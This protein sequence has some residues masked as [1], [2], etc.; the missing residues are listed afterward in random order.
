M[1]YNVFDRKAISKFI[2]QDAICKGYSIHL[3]NGRNIWEALI[4]CLLDC[5]YAEFGDIKII[6]TVPQIS[7]SSKLL[8]F[9]GDHF[10]R[11]ENRIP[12]ICNVNGNKVFATTDALPYLY[13]KLYL[14]NYLFSTYTVVRPRSFA[15][16][17]FLREEFIRYFQFVFA[18]EE[19]DLR[20]SID[21]IRTATIRF[22]ERIRIPVVLVDRHS[23][24]YYLKKSC[25]HSVWANLNIESVLQCGILRKS[26]DY[27]S[28]YKKRV[29]DIGGA[30]RLLA[31]FIYVNSDSHGLFL[32]YY[33]RN[34]DII[35]KSPKKS[36]ILDEFVRCVNN[37]GGRINYVSSDLSLRV[38]RRIAI[39]ESALAIVVQRVIDGKVFLTIYNR[40]MTKSEVVTIADV[41]DWIAKKYNL[42]E[43]MPSDL[44]NSIICSRIKEGKLYLR[45][46]SK[47]YKIINDGLFN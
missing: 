44:Q 31:S 29:I 21:K 17:P 42:I 38:I 10:D 45:K 9:Y 14:S 13:S 23:D 12:C 47:N 19:C 16:K 18:I 41:E 24:S 5:F 11:I 6:D 1:L 46:G 43:R 35:I 7:E 2:S 27:G 40:D 30:Q 39:K 36:A 32:P 8:D 26:F 34:F 15:V 4:N 22:F 25:F 28:G 20:C 33:M 37:V 3:P